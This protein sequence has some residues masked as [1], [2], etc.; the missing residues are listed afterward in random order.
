VEVEDRVVGT[1]DPDDATPLGHPLE[2]A[3]L[4]LS[5]TETSP[6]LLILAALAVALLDEHRMVPPS[7]F[8]EG[9]AQHPEEVVVGR[10]DRPVEV[11]LDDRLRLADRGEL[12]G[13]IR[14]LFG[15]ELLPGA[16]RRRG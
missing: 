11:E 1:L 13:V 7:H 5:P 3:A 16:G 8:L 4:V 6:E 9:I 14:H 2:L 10:E 12:A 15:G